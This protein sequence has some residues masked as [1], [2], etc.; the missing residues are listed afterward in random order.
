MINRTIKDYEIKELIATGGMAAIY[1]AT[2]ISTGQTVAIKVLHG[3]LAQDKDFITRFE[4]EARSA[5]DLKHENI[6]DIIGYGEAEGVYFIA[7]QYVEGKSL[8]DLINSAKFMPHEI[9]LAIVYEICRGLEHAH[10][11]GVVHR[12]IKPANILIG[13]DGNVKITD[14]GLAQAQDLTSITVT[15]AIVGTPAYMSPEQAAGKKIDTRSD[16]FSLGVVVYEMVTGTKPFQGE[17]YSSVIHAILTIPAPKPIEVN[18]I[19]SEK[20]SAIIERML[21]KDMDKRYQNITQISDAIYSY[22]KAQSIEVPN[23]QI[24]VFTNDPQRIS[25][26]M[27]QEAKETYFKRGLY[28]LTRGK[29]NLDDA[30]SAFTKVQYLDPAD[31]QAKKHLAALRRKKK[32][33]APTKTNELRTQKRSSMFKFAGIIGA[34]LLI[35]V[36]AA[37][38]YRNYRNH[39][40][41][42]TEYG[43]LYVDSKPTAAAVY[44]DDKDLEQNTPI[45]YDSIAVGE[46]VLEVRKKGYQPYTQDIEIKQGDTLSV[47]TRLI[48]DVTAIPTGGLAV[49]SKPSGAK[50]IIDGVDTGLKTPCTIEKLSPGRYK[51][52]LVKTGYRATDIT[53]NVQSGETTSVSA[54]LSKTQQSVAKQSKRKSYFKIN[55]APWAKIYIDG[56]YIETTPIARAL[57]VTPGT[58]SVRLVNPSFQAWQKNVKFKPGETVSLDIKLQPFAGYLKL[59][60]RPWADVYIDGKYYETTPIAGTINLPAGRHTIKLINPSFLTHEEVITVAANKTLRKSIELVSK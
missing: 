8:K 42:P 53:R 37:A 33:A 16:I 10:Q 5:A 26:N 11:K 48:K 2:Q 30:I 58:H 49:S 28:Y 6:I 46:H 51:I 36:F 23:R 15:G 39:E 56:K 19:V 13:K 25:Q 27:I 18:P 55:V 45:K 1:K 7:M 20:I 59:S 21:N 43:F 22:F 35:V 32:V 60:V 38:L 54:N 3:H 31:E 17:T 4:R 9:A 12:D 41:S 44:L 29:A 52:R 47:N 57:Q 40:V 14:F 50:V 24:S 34:I